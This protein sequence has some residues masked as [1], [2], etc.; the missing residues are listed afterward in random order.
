[1]SMI[2]K[3][4]DDM[5]PKWHLTAVDLPDPTG[6]V[7]TVKGW[8]ERPVYD[9]ETRTEVPT[10]CLVFKEFSKPFVGLNP[11][12]REKLA[13]IF[14]TRD[15]GN[16]VGKQATVYVTTAMFAGAEY[17]VLRFRNKGLGEEVIGQTDIKKASGNGDAITKFWAYVHGHDVAR[18]QAESLIKDSDGDFG[19]ALQVL[20][21]LRD[22]VEDLRGEELDDAV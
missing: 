4:I 14:G 19:A 5:F 10:W 15:L 20:E 11:T 18:Q 6:M 22:G 21:D 16:W 8:T 1:M 13:D 3:T 2:P 9:F 17:K 7:V 12:N